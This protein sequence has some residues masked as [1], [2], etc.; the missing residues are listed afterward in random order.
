MNLGGYS[1]TGPRETN[2]DSFY[3]LDFSDVD[4]FTGGVVAFAMV[5]DGMGGYQGGD[6][7]SNLAVACAKSYVKQLLEM[8][9][10][11]KVELDT[12]AALTEIARNAHEAILAERAKRDNASV[13]ATFVGAFL[14]PTHAWIGHIGDSRAYL[15]RDGIARQ[16]TED[17]SQVGRLLSRGVITEEE[18]QNHPARNRIERALG[19]SDGDA[20][21]DEVDL[22]SGDALLLCSDGVYTALDAQ[23]LGTCVTRSR[24]AAHAAKRAVKLAL[25]RGTDD[26]STA[27]VVYNVPTQQSEPAAPTQ[28]ATLHGEA[29]AHRVTAAEGVKPV[30]S[31]M[32]QTSRQTRSATRTVK[33]RRPQTRPTRQ[34]QAGGARQSRSTISLILPL[35]VL[36]LMIGLMVVFFI[37]A[38]VPTSQSAPTAIDA[39][40]Q[41]AENQQA[42]PTQGDTLGQG[43]DAAQPTDTD[44]TSPESGMSTNTDVTSVISQTEIDANRQSG[45]EQSLAATTDT[46]P[47]VPMGYQTY[48]LSE[49]IVLKYVDGNGLAQTFTTDPIWLNDA[50]R[51]RRG[52]SVV[53]KT[54]DEAYGRIER[55]YQLLAHDYRDEL[56]SDL[57][58][59][60]N[61]STSFDSELSQL[62]G[63]NHYLRLL[64]G[65]SEYGLD[66]VEEQVASL[67]IDA[68]TPT[69][70]GES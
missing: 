38:Q 65:L 20:E 2:E 25:S 70:E 37:K 16:L 69:R 48:Q 7:A 66:E 55:T 28:G 52:T 60:I 43:D 44:S 9:Q 10:G 49:A 11:N 18:A 36:I 61:G 34:E 50:P 32:R 19:F 8:A 41:V 64:G 45:Q 26:N 54:Q 35:I 63:H 6:V 57:A 15:I 58:S 1:A 4:A 27:V 53:I 62:I 24:D 5:S 39:A 59:Y 30:R 42:A 68:V 13:G 17:H 21:I 31:T 47:A 22:A 3:L 67:A 40:Q 33:R 14:S 12:A 29:T 51:L 56:C 46:Q 23:T